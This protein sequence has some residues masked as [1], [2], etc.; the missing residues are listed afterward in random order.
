[1]T[2]L[3]SIIIAIATLVILI[4]SCKPRI[5]K[6]AGGLEYKIINDKPGDKIVP[7]DYVFFALTGKVKDSIFMNSN[8]NPNGFMIEMKDP[9]KKG[10]F[11]EVLSMLSAGDSAF[12]RIKAD[13]FFM[14]YL[15]YRRLPEFVKS[16]SNI[17]FNI[18]ID[19]VVTKKVVEER[20]L[21]QAK[22]DEDEMKR[23]QEEEPANI[24]NY[25]K[26][27]GNNFTKTSN[28]L[29]YKITKATSGKKAQNGDTVSVIYTGKLLNGKVFDAS[30]L[31][32]G[33]PYDLVLGE[34]GVIKGWEDALLLMHEGEKAI[35]V[36]PSTLGYGGQAMG[37][38]IRPYSPLMFELELV[39]VKHGKK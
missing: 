16:G 18:H 12:F 23:N 32:G 7:G 9:V 36:I 2:K 20:K 24:E 25:I 39:K 31:H 38:D 17:D 34:G 35:V 37:E 27:N 1:M 10:N 30:D 4:S 8:M 26:E 29:Y 14:G 3:S 11:E 21:A 15:G 28:G 22:K 6:T 33:A 19:S 13:T 5:R